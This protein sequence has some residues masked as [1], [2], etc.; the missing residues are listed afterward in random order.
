MFLIKKMKEIL[1]DA[2]SRCNRGTGFE[3]TFKIF[4][5][6]NNIERKAITHLLGQ[7][8]MYVLGVVRVRSLILLKSLDEILDLVWILGFDGPELRSV[9]TNKP[10]I[11]N[12]IAYNYLAQQARVKAS[13]K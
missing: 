8:E 12:H 5:A 1:D 4:K 2:S 13:H 9:L 7:L 3:Q 6:I 11:A 10:I